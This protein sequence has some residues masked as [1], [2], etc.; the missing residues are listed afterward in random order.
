M[1]DISIRTLY[2]V[3]QMVIECPHLPCSKG[4]TE[5]V[6][7][8]LLNEVGPQAVLYPY[9]NQEETVLSLWHECHSVEY[10]AQKTGVPKDIVEGIIDTPGNYKE[11]IKTH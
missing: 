1:K 4:I 9:N 7:S 8:V 3:K 10:I 11:L 5:K 2:Q 6:N